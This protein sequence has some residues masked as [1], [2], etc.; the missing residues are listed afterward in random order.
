MM[1]GI[2]RFVRDGM[3]VGRVVYLGWDGVYVSCGEAGSTCAFVNLWVD[4]MDSFLPCV[5]MSCELFLWMYI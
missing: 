1:G 2:G 5:C 4:G 3:W